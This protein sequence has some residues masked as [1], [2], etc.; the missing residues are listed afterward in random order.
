MEQYF[1]KVDSHSAAFKQQ[2]ER[3]HNRGIAKQGKEKRARERDEKDAQEEERI[4]Q[5]LLTNMTTSA[6]GSSSPRRKKKM[7]INPT[8]QQ[9]SHAWSET[10]TT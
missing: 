1:T 9:K 10:P 6:L 5:E 4:K 8:N 3:E 2:Q 7:T